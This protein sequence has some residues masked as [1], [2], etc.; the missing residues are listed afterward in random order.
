MTH[1]SLRHEI[2]GPRPVYLDVTATSLTRASA[3]VDR[4]VIALAQGALVQ[5]LRPACGKHQA[6]ENQGHLDVRLQAYPAKD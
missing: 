3:S 5:C 6:P 1:V 2:R 4:C